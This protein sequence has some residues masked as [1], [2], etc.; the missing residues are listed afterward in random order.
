MRSPAA[1]IVQDIND[2]PSPYLN[3][4]FDLKKYRVVD[5][6]LSRGCK[7]R[8]SYCII[9][10]NPLRYFS[11]DRI[12]AELE[13]LVKKAPEL[14]TISL[15]T[16]DLLE[17]EKF[18]LKLLP[19]M[20]EISW[21]R[22]I[23]FIFDIN[24]NSLSARNIE[25]MKLLNCADFE[26]EIGVQ[27]RNNEVLFSCGRPGSK[28]I[29]EGFELLKKHAPGLSVTIGIIRGLPGDDINGYKNA[30]SWVFSTGYDLQVRH[31]RILP[32]SRLEKNKKQYGIEI[33]KKYPYF[34]SS[35]NTI[36]RKNMLKM[37][38]LTEDACFSYKMIRMSKALKDNF[39]TSAS[40]LKN[41]SEYP[42]L[43]FAEKFTI[44][45][46]KSRKFG[47]IYRD[48]NQ[49]RKSETLDWELDYGSFENV[50]L[51]ALLVEFVKFKSSWKATKPAG[52]R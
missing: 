35:V 25:L 14:S 12:K 48:Y 28:G 18:A 39:L 2:I 43:E 24:V 51:R 50:S 10:E 9:G 19:L 44:W 13:V 16:T 5:L 3:G 22:G 47:K 20:R 52:K 11:F 4:V 7:W 15:I 8:C 46:G 1:N 32:G 30:L 21:K 17:N 45:L 26:A 42:H 27:S 40:E 31:L 34:V 36:P 41:N 6:L 38:R 37:V 33:I 49:K 23:K 29:E